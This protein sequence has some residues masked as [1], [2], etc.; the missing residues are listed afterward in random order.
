MT[1]KA[2]LIA[3][4]LVA[5]TVQAEAGWL[6]QLDAARLEVEGTI[7]GQGTL[8]A[9]D[10]PTREAMQ[11][12]LIA[13]NLRVETDQANAT[14]VP[15]GALQ[16][17][18]STRHDAWQTVQA[19]GL[20][21][22]PGLVVQVFAK[23]GEAAVAW[24]DHGADVEA[25]SNALAARQRVPADRALPEIPPGALQWTS[26]GAGTT[27][28]TGNF[29]LV[30][31]DIHVHILHDGGDTVLAT[32]RQDEPLLGLPD[33]TT[34]A[35]ARTSDRQAYITVTQGVLELSTKDAILHLANAGGLID[36]TVRAHGAQGQLAD[37]TAPRDVTEATLELSGVFDF[38]ALA[39]NSGTH[40]ELGGV[41]HDAKASGQPLTWAAG[42]REPF[43]IAW[44]VVVAGAMLG[45]AVVVGRAHS[46][47]GRM[48]RIESHRLAGRHVRV[49]NHTR[50]LL[51][52]ATFGHDA[53]LLHV[54][55]LVRMGQTARA[56]AMLEDR[57][58]WPPGPDPTRTYLRALVAAAEHQWAAARRYLQAALRQD[59]R[60]S[61][62]AATEPLLATLRGM[63]EGY[64]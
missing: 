47:R 35:L 63:P 46:P 2:L 6:A 44:V 62:A 61:G 43:P 37:G 49:A 60:M 41:V 30:L 42:L 56:Q 7:T 53:R 20:T 19:Q 59:P 33:E 48:A 14:S 15:G 3:L 8:L 13:E 12:R 17:E 31:Y 50:R 23:E 10:V 38:A 32:G 40:I 57:N 1:T 18:F 21:S 34:L 58:V 22:G 52:S 64:S 5:P 25:S 29:L 26:Q 16:P 24:A 45:A 51:H 28:V 11:L 27:R 55:A 36:G 54:E 39:R 4:L 9:L